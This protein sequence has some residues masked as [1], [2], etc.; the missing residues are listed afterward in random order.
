MIF[1]LGGEPPPN[2]KTVSV[3]SSHPMLVHEKLPSKSAIYTHFFQTSFCH[4]NIT[5]YT[6]NQT[7]P[8]QQKV[9]QKVIIKKKIVFFS[10]L[11]FFWISTGLL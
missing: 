11:V 6:L 3:H 2:L 9:L 10:F 4:N 5:Q 1:F 8:G 7:N